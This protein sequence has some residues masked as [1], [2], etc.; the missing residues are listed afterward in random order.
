MLAPH[1]P[2]LGALDEVGR[3]LLAPSLNDVADTLNQFPDL[4][5]QDALNDNQVTCK[6]WLIDQV[7]SAL[8]GTFG[9]VYVLGGWYGVLAA[10]LLSDQRFS[11][12]QVISI[13]LDPACEA[14]AT[15][16]NQTHSR[17]ASFTAVTANMSD[18][19]YRAIDQEG[20][21]GVNGGS[22]SN[23]VVNT[24]CEH[25]SPSENWYGQIPDGTCQVFQSNDYFACDEHVNCVDDIDAFRAQLP[26]TEILYQGSLK[27]RRYTRFMIIGR[28]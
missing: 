11:L 1:D 8:G 23:L 12:R 4:S 15:S 24:S 28:K 18:F 21:P 16:L 27:R 3:Y 14:V 25:M 22:K 20:T 7:H 19:S 5:L 26:M 9:T 2:H 10:L 6:R 13:D 17:S